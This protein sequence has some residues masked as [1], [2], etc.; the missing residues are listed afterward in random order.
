MTAGSHALVSTEAVLRREI[1]ELRNHLD[2]AEA[3]IAAIRSGAADAI[4][5][6]TP[7]GV[8]VFTL[9]GSEHPYRIMV[10]TM[11]EGAVTVAADGLVLYC[12]ERFAEMLESDLQEIIGHSFVTNFDACDAAT[13]ASALAGD[14]RPQS[15]FRA[16]L[17]TATRRLRPVS[18]AVQRLPEDSP[19]ASVVVLSDLTDLVNEHEARLARERE[20]QRQMQDLNHDLEYRVRR[21]T[22]ELAAANEELDAFAYSVSHDLRAPLRAVD[23]FANI[24]IEDYDTK[25]DE[26]GKHAIARVREGAQR[27]SALIDDMLRLS[28]ATRGTMT[29]SKVDL[30]AM[31][32]SSAASL[33]EAQPDRNV[34]FSIASDISAL[35]DPGLVR[36]VID[37]LLS[38][39]WKFTANTPDAVIKFYGETTD[40]EVVC[41]SRDNGAGFDMAYADKLFR[42]FQRLHDLSEYPGNGIG[43]ATVRRIITRMGGKISAQG[44]PNQGGNFHLLLAA[45]C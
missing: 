7:T 37:N 24:L 35:G 19:A 20:F 14:S 10:E 44:A 39:A 45:K 18:L 6:E 17:H 3:I 27:M 32:R 30:S 11:N 13:V 5:M 1:A 23:G 4:A 28:R 41:H 38:N 16:S 42:P 31:V 22:A 9:Q 36:A 29:L 34:T 40:S 33:R 8:S 26:G 12:N 15:R 43:L 21:R 2:E 25:L